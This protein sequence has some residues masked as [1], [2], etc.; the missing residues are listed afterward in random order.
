MT[1]QELHD[2][3]KAKRDQVDAIS[4]PVQEKEIFR[5]ELLKIC[6]FI[7]AINAPADFS[8]LTRE[9]YD[10]YADLCLKWTE[11]LILSNEY[12]L[13]PEMA[14]C[15][16]QLVS[17]WNV[18]KEKKL[19]VFTLGNFQVLKIKREDNK[20]YIE[21]LETMSLRTGIPQTYEPVFIRVPDEYKDQM[22]TNVPLFHEV[23]H[24]VDRDNS[25]TDMVYDMIEDELTKSKTSR[26][27][28]EHFPRFINVELKDNQEAEKIIRNH[29]SEYIA[30]VFGAQYAHEYILLPAKYVVPEPAKDDDDHPSL[31][32]R[33]RFV[34]VFIDY[35]KTGECSNPLL[36]AILEVLNLINKIELCP[37]QHSANDLL[38]DQLTFQNNDELLSSFQVAWKAVIL[39]SKRARIIGRQ[40]ED[41]QKI[42]NLKSFKQIDTNIRNAT[43]PLV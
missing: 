15:I 20:D 13:N 16:E 1:Y 39:D 10:S 2:D 31:D 33:R 28:R 41:Y 18:H 11:R 24:F 8:P 25:V 37:D 6:D 40:R 38:S 14:Y 32:C 5:I 26:F 17:K 27:L 30:D 12:R 43:T 4:F 9:E 22:L 29:I 35:C 36:L 3:L 34:N 23:G 42:L 7:L 19:V 21:Y